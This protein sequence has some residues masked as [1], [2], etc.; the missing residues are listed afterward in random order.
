MTHYPSVRM[1]FLTIKSLNAPQKVFKQQLL[2]LEQKLLLKE[3]ESLNF[4]E[5]DFNILKMKSYLQLKSLKGINPVD[6]N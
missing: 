5:L 6:Y 2:N 1:N 4:N 3:R